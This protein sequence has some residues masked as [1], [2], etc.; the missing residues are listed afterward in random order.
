MELN[1][2]ELNIEYSIADWRRILYKVL[3]WE[4]YDLITEKQFKEFISS[5]N[6]DVLEEKSYLCLTNLF[7]WLEDVYKTNL[8]NHNHN[9]TILSI[10]KWNAE[11]LKFEW[12]ET[13]VQDEFAKYLISSF[14]PYKFLNALSLQDL[15][16]LKERINKDTTKPFF[17][18]LPQFEERITNIIKFKESREKN[19]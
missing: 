14:V 7:E 9:D 8:Y 13:E 1:I 19:D 18:P 11:T 3:S 17:N 16:S 15:K 4:S 2:K 10:E 12:S 5:I 6:F